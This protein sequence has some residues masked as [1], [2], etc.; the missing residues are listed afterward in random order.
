MLT[1]GSRSHKSLLF[2]GLLFPDLTVYDISTFNPCENHSENESKPTQLYHLV[3]INPHGLTN[4]RTSFLTFPLHSKNLVPKCV[5]ALHWF[6]HCF[7]LSKPDRVCFFGIAAQSFAFLTALSGRWQQCTCWP[8]PVVNFPHPKSMRFLHRFSH[9]LLSSFLKC[10]FQKSSSTMAG[11]C[12][13]IHWQFADFLS[14]C[15]LYSRS[16]S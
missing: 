4:N 13:G 9:R 2:R 5:S 7:W 16:T 8:D 1:L 15:V 14:V 11:G 10:G 6:V 12:S 3:S